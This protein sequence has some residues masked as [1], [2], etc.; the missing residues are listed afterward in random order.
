MTQD[1]KLNMVILMQNDLT[2]AVAFY[3]DLGLSLAFHISH[4]WAEFDVHGV[5]LGL[6][7]TAQELPER[8]TGIVFEVNDLKSY[9]ESHKGDIHF[10]GEPVEAVH[11]VI[12]SFKDPGNNILDLYQPTPEKVKEA[13][14]KAARDAEM[15]DGCC[16]HEHDANKEEIKKDDS[17]C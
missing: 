2:R 15:K 9:Y 6:A 1:I 5:K 10:L 3:R 8:R 4:K 14:Q 12:A 7:E 16:D 17:C 11:G 13:V